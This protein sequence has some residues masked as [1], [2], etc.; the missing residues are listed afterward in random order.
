MVLDATLMRL[1]HRHVSHSDTLRAVS[2]RHKPPFIGLPRVDRIGRINGVGGPER[3]RWASF[4]FLLELI[5][6]L[7]CQNVSEYIYVTAE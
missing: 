6:F 1:F 5:R 4:S 2:E 3:G 7:R